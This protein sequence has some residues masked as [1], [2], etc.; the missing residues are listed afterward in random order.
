MHP[1]RSIGNFVGAL[2]VYI[3]IVVHFNID[4]SLIESIFMGIGLAMATLK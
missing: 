1:Y 2:I 4:I 3:T